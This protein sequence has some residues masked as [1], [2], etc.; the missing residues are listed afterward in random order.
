MLNLQ[1]LIVLHE[2]ERRGSLAAVAQSLNYSPSAVS[3][4]LATLEREV[5]T[6][7][8]E[9]IGRGVRLTDAARI[10][11]EHTRVAI[12]A[13]ESAEAALAA[14]VG[15]VAGSL[16]IASLQT[17]L[18]SLLPAVLQ[19]LERE[20]P[21]LHV[22]VSQR[23]VSE[24]V[25]G[26]LAGTFDVVVGE[27]YPGG[28][29]PSHAGLHRRDLGADEMLLA[30]PSSGPWSAVHSLS[31]VATAPWALD[32]ANSAPGRWARATCRD[33]GFEPDVR[34]DGVDLLV[35][36]QMVRAGRAV[37]LVP[38]LLRAEW[39]HGVRLVELRGAPS[40]RLFTLTRS[41]RVSHPAVNAF[42]DALATAFDAQQSLAAG[43]AR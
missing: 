30:V 38:S 5:G 24:A 26:L 14:S 29:L 36:L 4:Q 32:P 8:T 12:A 20:H 27:E 39:A 2:L 28:S 34:F 7:L 40:R 22:D 35:H 43:R 6:A 11:V 16:H 23:D 15:A 37:S 25:S 19:T 31:E 9:P 10:L 18:L 13:I 42:R 41:A 21:E 17:A 33:S 3:Q 1:R